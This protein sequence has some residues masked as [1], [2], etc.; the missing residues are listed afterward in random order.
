MNSTNKP[1]LIREKIVS[2]FIP[3]F[4]IVIAL[5]LGTIL[6][7]VF[8]KDPIS[9]YKAL[10]KGSFGNLQAFTNTLSRSTPIIFTSIGAAIA[11]K[12]GVF[13]M[14]VEGQLNIGGMAAAIAGYAIPGLPPYIHIPLCILLGALGG[15]IW[16]LIPALMKVYRGVH[17]IIS[18]IM[19]NYIA[20]SLTSYLTATLRDSGVPQTPFIL[21]SAKMP[22]MASLDGFRGSTL[23]MGFVIAIMLCFVI[24]VFL[25][26]TSA[27][28]EIRSVGLNIEASRAAGIKVNKS[29]ITAM[30][31]SGAL[32]GIGGM[33]RV[34]GVHKAFIT[35]FSPGYG[36]EG[37]AA[38]L[39]AS[40]NPIGA[41]FSSVMFGT[42]A[43]GGLHMEMSAGVPSQVV[44][45]VQ[46]LIILCVAVNAFFKHI[47]FKH[48]K[49]REL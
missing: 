25:N 3:L 15:A 37:V 48:K 5:L 13:N 12:C 14:G 10:I 17:E 16:A 35:G 6:I 27:G 22:S 36:F 39:I 4:S 30:I 45:I 18:T 31:I 9:A 41:I 46:G 42:L 38:S 2:F 49:R 47:I 33:E 21:P 24:Y 20:V 43:N 11:F 28:F 7:V 26:R 32:A 40:N 8:K 34:L 23:N 44:S 1:K 19:M 29:V